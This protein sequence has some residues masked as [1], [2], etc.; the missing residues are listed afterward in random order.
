MDFAGQRV[1]ITEVGNKLN[2]IFVTVLMSVLWLHLLLAFSEFV[3]RQVAQN[4]TTTY[5]SFCPSIFQM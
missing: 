1:E 5:L 4:K 2:E 3:R